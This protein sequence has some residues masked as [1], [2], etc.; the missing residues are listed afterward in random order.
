MVY[1]ILLINP[2]STE[3]M[4]RQMAQTAQAIAAD[5]ARI[6]ARTNFEGPAA[7]QGSRDGVLAA[8]GVLQILASESFDVGILG[9]FDDTALEAAREGSLVPVI[10]IGQASFHTACLLGR[11]FGVLTTLPVSVPV[12][13]DNLHRL[14]MTGSCAGVVAS[15]IPV[16]EL[17]R[18]P[19][20]SLVRLQQVGQEMLATLHPDVLVLGCAGMTGIAGILEQ[21]LGIPVVDPIAA[22]TV[23]ALGLARLRYGS[24]RLSAS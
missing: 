8:P 17:E 24:Q 18:D 23:M 20:G 15:G 7:L 10:G 19:T 3:A 14:N 16:L 4:T 5:Q 1:Q 6:L 12:I 9:C 13:E 22:A 2:N 11:R 21:S